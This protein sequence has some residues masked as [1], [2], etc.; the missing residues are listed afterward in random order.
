MI[1]IYFSSNLHGEETPFAS[2]VISKKQG[3]RLNKNTLSSVYKK[4]T[5]TCEGSVI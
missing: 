2:N 1:G 5:S 3:G 4:E